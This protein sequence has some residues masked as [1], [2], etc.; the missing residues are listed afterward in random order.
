MTPLILQDNL[1]E[2]ISRIL[3]GC[4]YKTPAGE[5]IPI[6]V[7]KQALPVNE[8]DDDADPVP[9]I[10]VRLQNGEDKGTGD[11]TN[12]VSLVVVIGVWDDSSDSQGYRDVM[13][14]IQ[15]IY[16]RF[17]KDPILNGIAAYSGEFDWALNE[18]DYYPYF[19]GACSLKFHIA[20]IR[21]EDRYT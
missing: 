10:I 13:N 9:Y 16:E 4:L 17:H 6:H 11:S 14:I 12:T 20:A 18:D 2:E 15:K 19:F 1:A 7:F 5:R 21:R 3:D 8:A